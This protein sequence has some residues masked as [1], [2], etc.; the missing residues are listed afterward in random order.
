M[1]DA[2]ETKP[3]NWPL[4]AGIFLVPFIFSWFMHIPLQDEHLLQLKM[5]TPC[6]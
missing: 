5:I 6:D 4:M 2:S 1:N 3:T